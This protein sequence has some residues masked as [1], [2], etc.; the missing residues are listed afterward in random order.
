MIVCR[1]PRYQS[2]Y[3]WFNGKKHILKDQAVFI[4]L[5]KEHDLFEW[6]FDI[7]IP[8]LKVSDALDMTNYI[9]SCDTLISNATFGLSLGIGL[10]TV[11]ILQEC[12]SNAPNAVFPLKK[13]M[14]YV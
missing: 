2:N 12:N 10:G 3:P 14:Y 7:K 6:T 4:G 13:N 8:Y 11:T 1:S 5:E 9:F